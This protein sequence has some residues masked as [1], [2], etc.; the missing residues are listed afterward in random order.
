M[1][2]P[3]VNAAA[4]FTRR[5]AGWPHAVGIYLL[6]A[7]GAC[8]ML[9]P[10]AWLARS[11]LMGIN[12]IFR[13]PPEWIPDPVQWQNFPDALTTVP[14][15]LYLKNT[16]FILLPS[17]AGTVAT[18]ALAAFG[19]SRLRWRGRDLTF[20]V[21]L[22]TLMLPYA[23]TLIPTF[24]LWARLG[25]TN[26]AW[27]LVLP[28][29][30]GG[31][32]FYIFLLRQFFRTIPREQDEAATLDGAN[33]LEILWHVIVPQ[34]KPALVAVAI[35]SALNAWNDFLG[36]LIYLNDSS[37]FTLALGLAEFTGLYSSQW[38]LLMAAT[39]LVVLPVVALFFM[40]Q[41][42]LIQGITLTGKQR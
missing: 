25:L 15:L 29:W 12:Q 26:T 39:I 8:F 41:R 27:P 21:L 35:F 13:F 17:V 2:T 1:K 31:G 28:R 42:Y 10:F 6:C 24:L 37:K 16:L 22:A 14:F 18:S 11:S 5:F 36:P 23:I 9:L 40:T 30:F 38:H 34:S 19:F 20:N 32:A 33:P 4:P 7:G 3:T